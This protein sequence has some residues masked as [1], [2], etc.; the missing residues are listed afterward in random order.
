VRARLLASADESKRE[1]IQKVLASIS[2]EIIEENPQTQDVQ[3]AIRLAQMMKETGRLNEAELI[4]Y[5]R[6]QKYSEAVAV[7]AAICGAPYELID[8]LMHSDRSDALLV[9]CKAAGLSWNAVRALLEMGARGSVGEHDIE[10]ASSEFK[11]L[12]Q[13]TAG[14]VLRFWQVRQT[15]GAPPTT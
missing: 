9:P 10:T 5:A 1:E 8:R 11:K 2:A 6:Q 15:A 14:R 4:R 7:L 3:E 13:Q 12:S